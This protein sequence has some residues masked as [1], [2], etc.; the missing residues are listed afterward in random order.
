MIHTSSHKNLKSNYYLTYA[1]SGNRG[2]DAGY[3]GKCYP[4]LA[5]K[6]SF[7]REWHDNIGK[8]SEEENNRFYIEEYYKQVLSNLDSEKVYSDLDHSIL[9]CYED[10]E[11]FC[12]R[13][14]VAAW[15]ELMLDVHVP[16]LKNINGK[17]VEVEKP[18]YSKEYLDDVIRRNI[19]MLG[20]KSIRARY[21]FYQS[22]QL[23]QASIY[24]T[25]PQ[26]FCNLK[27][28]AAYL[29]CDA[30]EVEAEYTSSLKLNRKKN[31]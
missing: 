24:E 17:L 28:Q 2:K 23:E 31:I 8:V 7:W 5:P 16:E 19:N 10:N 21:L 11:E 25:N 14:I 9:L 20:F 12:H 4:T 15:F 3:T 13:H 22:E 1:I 27:Q 6:L 18:A 29:R 26:K 30:D